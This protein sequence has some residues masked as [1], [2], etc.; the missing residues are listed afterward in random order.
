MVVEQIIGVK[1]ERSYNVRP[2]DAVAGGGEATQQPRNCV[3]RCVIGKRRT[4]RANSEKKH[5]VADKL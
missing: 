4:V 1:K 5:S 2:L 3:K